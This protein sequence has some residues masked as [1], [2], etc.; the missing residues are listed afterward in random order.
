MMSRTGGEL[1]TEAGPSSCA[2]ACIQGTSL[3]HCSLES[4]LIISGLQS[5][6]KL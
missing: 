6:R 4:N 5:K 2:C 1:Q 3:F